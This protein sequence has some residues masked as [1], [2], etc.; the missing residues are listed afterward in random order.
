[1]NNLVMFLAGVFLLIVSDACENY[2]HTPIA[3]FYA[4]VLAVFGSLFV[5]LPILDLLED[6]DSHDH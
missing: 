4:V 5:W 2:W 3:E 6:E 1:M